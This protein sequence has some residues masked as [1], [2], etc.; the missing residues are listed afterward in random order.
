M[1][2]INKNPDG[3]FMDAEQIASDIITTK[4]QDHK[5]IDWI[6]NNYTDKDRKQPVY[7]DGTPMEINFDAFEQSQFG[8]W[9]RNSY[10]L[11][12]PANPYTGPNP[13]LKDG[14][15]RTNGIIDDPRFPDNYSG[16]VMEM[17]VE[18]I[19]GIVRSLSK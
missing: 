12:D 4:I 2:E 10:G 13:V 3:T 19:R 8:R 14:Y 5:T 9:I 15:T 17:L 1:E 16:F 6:Y 18:K 11:W 7:A